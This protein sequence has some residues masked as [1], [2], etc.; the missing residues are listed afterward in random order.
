MW[1]LLAQTAVYVSHV[2]TFVV[3]LYAACHDEYTTG[4][5]KLLL[6]FERVQRRMCMRRMFGVMHPLVGCLAIGSIIGAVL[7][8]GE[9]DNLWA[10]LRIIACHYLSSAA[11]LLL[12]QGMLFWG[13]SSECDNN[14]GDKGKAAAAAD[15]A[16]MDL[17]TILV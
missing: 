13:I 5:D 12:L 11:L 1:P 9:N 15:V 7:H 2:I 14:R 8:A 6:P 3:L 4:K 16:D 10:L 17:P